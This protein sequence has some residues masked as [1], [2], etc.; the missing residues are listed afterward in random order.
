MSR[1]LPLSRIVDVDRVLVEG[2]QRPDRA[3]HYGHWMGVP[4]EA[5]EEAV[6]LGVQHGVVGDHVLEF[7][8]LGGRRQFAM[9][10]EV[11]DLQEARLFGQLLDGIAAVEQ[12]ALVAIDKRDLAF[13]RGCRGEARVEREAV[14]VGVELAD[15]D[16][17]GTKRTLQDRQIERLV[18][19]A[20]R[21]LVRHSRLLYPVPARLI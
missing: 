8:E 13:A 18:V 12:D 6:E 19:D 7:G 2:G 17:L 20:Q 15:V 11:A 10:Q 14:R 9:Q 16:D 4:P 3:R 1:N 5:L 21:H